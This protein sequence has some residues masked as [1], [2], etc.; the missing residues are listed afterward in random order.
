MRC[1][2]TLT[3]L[4]VNSYDLF[5]L[6]RESYICSVTKGHKHHF[7]PFLFFILVKFDLMTLK[8]RGLNLLIGQGRKV[9]V[10]NN[11]IVIITLQLNIR[12][13]EKY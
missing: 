6:L 13:A 9:G 8:L 4:A 11:V 12:D 3:R 7:I 2:V 5:N 10:A 1:N